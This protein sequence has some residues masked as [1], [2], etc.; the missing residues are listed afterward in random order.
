MLPKTTNVKLAISGVQSLSGCR[1][2]IDPQ[3][4]ID[5]IFELEKIELDEIK[6]SNRRYPYIDFKPDR[7]AG[8]HILDVKN[9]SLTVDGE[10]VLNNINLI[11]LMENGC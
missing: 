7:E 4:E 1:I 6:P 10:K 3:N 9:V 5:E 2:V 8:D 11:V